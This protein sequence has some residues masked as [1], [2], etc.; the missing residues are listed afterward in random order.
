MENFSKRYSSKQ[1]HY[2]RKYKRQYLKSNFRPKLL[3]PPKTYYN[4]QLS[5]IKEG[6]KGWANAR[7][8]FHNDR[9][10]SFSINLEEGS[11]KCHYG[12][13]NAKG[14]SIV[15]F[16]MKRYGLSFTDAAKELGGLR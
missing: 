14:G 11:F 2:S 15:S 10:P 12:G 3:I 4:Q 9:H 7:C 13:C 16:H 6:R 5:G 1:P 8:P